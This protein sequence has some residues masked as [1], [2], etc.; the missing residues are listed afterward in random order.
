MVHYFQSMWQCNDCFLSVAMPRDWFVFFL[1]EGVA[2][3]CC[4]CSCHVS[5]TMW[6]VYKR[7]GDAGWWGPPR[8][9]SSCERNAYVGRSHILTSP[10]VILDLHACLCLLL[11]ALFLQ[12]TLWV[13]NWLFIKPFKGNISVHLDLLFSQYYTPGDTGWWIWILPGGSTL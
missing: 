1:A 11:N 10:A 4:L 12:K 2:T 6:C 7:T 3:C 5:L 9:G 13:A 8:W